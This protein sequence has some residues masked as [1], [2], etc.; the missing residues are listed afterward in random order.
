MM[1]KKSKVEGANI[2]VYDNQ[3]AYFELLKSNFSQTHQF[4]LFNSGQIE[5]AVSEYDMLFFFIYDELELLD[6]IKLYR[7]DIPVVLGHWALNHV[8]VFEEQGN[9]HYLHLNKLKGEIISDVE[10][11]LKT[12]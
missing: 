9:I 7:N 3:Q 1:N 10:L 5:S 2:L 8:E 12:L 6:F 11:L 4:N